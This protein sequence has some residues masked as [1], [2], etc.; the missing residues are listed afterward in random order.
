MKH[1]F[2]DRVKIHARAGR[3]GDG[4]VSFRREKYEPRGGPDGGSGGKGGDVILQSS[5]Q[6]ATLID[7]YY[8]P[9]VHASPGGRGGG[10]NRRGRD[11]KNLV[12][13][14]PRGTL[15]RKAEDGS[16]LVDLAEEE[17]R[18]V[19]VRGGKGGRGNASFAT[20]TEQAPR[21][22]E[23][24]TPGEEGFF[25]LELKLIADVGLVGC[26]NAGKSS[27]I[28]R[29]SNARPR[30]ASYPFTTLK[31]VLGVMT[32]PEEERLV[33]ADIP[34]LL[35][36]AHRN[37]GLGHDF[38]KHIE[39]TRILLLVIDMAGE[40]GRTPWSDYRDLRRELALYDRKLSRRPFLTAANKMDLPG[41]GANLEIFI[42]RT[43]LPADR[44]LPVSAREGFGLEKLRAAIFRLSA[45]R[46]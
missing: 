34:G 19:L 37:E 18:F 17:Q 46:R 6:L 32:G 2:I 9:R 1:S 11:G 12:V 41:A 23:A 26:P 22:A 25:A 28:S 7:Y 10:K 14:V 31:P 20:A 42:K 27:L 24:G 21:E 30:I 33:L 45:G 16:L 8:L 35:E 38:L 36:G 39:R 44:V 29:L 15:V 43:R 3:G 4:C 5:G 40:E 13:K